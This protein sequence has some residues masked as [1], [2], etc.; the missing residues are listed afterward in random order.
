MALLACELNK[1]EIDVNSVRIVFCALRFGEFR[2]EFRA[3]G[4]DVY[5]NNKNWKSLKAAQD[6]ELC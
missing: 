6:D 4:F 2:F 1:S 5:A 3:Q